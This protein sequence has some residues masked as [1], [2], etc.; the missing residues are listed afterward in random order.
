MPAPEWR[1]QRGRAHRISGRPAFCIASPAVQQAGPVRVYLLR[2]GFLWYILAGF[3]MDLSFLVCT[4]L[5]SLNNPA[6]S[7]VGMEKK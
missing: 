2:Q 7:Q 4:L 1:G 6:Q 3:G 5:S